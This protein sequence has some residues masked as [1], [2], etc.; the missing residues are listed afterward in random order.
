ME[1]AGKRVLVDGKFPDLTEEDVLVLVVA[2]GGIPATAKKADLLLTAKKESKAAASFREAGK[3]VIA[4]ED[5]GAPLEGWLARFKARVAALARSEKKDFR[6]FAAGGGASKALL[7]RIAKRVGFDLPADFKR[8]AESFD[9]LS[10]LHVRSAKTLDL[11]RDTLVPWARF[12]SS[13]DPIWKTFGGATV[14]A[15]A[16]VPWEEMFFGPPYFAVAETPSGA[17]DVQLGKQKLAVTSLPGRLF[18]FDMYHWNVNAALYAD[19]EARQFFVIHAADS[20]ANLAVSE[21]IPLQL[22]VEGLLAG[23]N[24]SNK[25]D[26]AYR[27]PG[28]MRYWR[29]LT[30]APGRTSAVSPFPMLRSSSLGW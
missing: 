7:D 4:P 14:A 12:A 23:G 19:P 22:Y 11:P 30:D 26:W 27:A 18:P 21:R 24:I 10:F 3:L 16:I 17:G 28:N 2:H 1:I 25:I 8:L 20:G 15:V 29:P 6:N 5:L 9:G 13:Q